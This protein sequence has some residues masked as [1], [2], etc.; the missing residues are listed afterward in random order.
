MDF[1]SSHARTDHYNR[2]KEK[3]TTYWT[4]PPF[5][6]LRWSID[7]SIIESKK[8][9]TVN[10]VCRDDKRIIFIARGD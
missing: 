10:Y 6:W 5:N 8:S 1:L 9:T 2:R 4:P 3:S 7:A